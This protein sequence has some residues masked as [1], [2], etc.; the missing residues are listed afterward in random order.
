MR[1][2]L[3]NMWKCK[4]QCIPTYLNTII[5]Y[6]ARNIA[7]LR[8][9]ISVQAGAQYRGLA[10]GNVVGGVRGGRGGRGRQ[11]WG[12]GFLWPPDKVELSVRAPPLT[13]ICI[14]GG[15]CG[16]IGADTCACMQFWNAT[17]SA[18]RTN[19]GA[20]TRTHTRAYTLSS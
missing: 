16:H 1:C 17:R 4:R 11:R 18:A 13:R 5:N 14:C 9:R 3:V 7:H 2:T 8:D 15:A 20:R 10:P 6:P 12:Q 19:T